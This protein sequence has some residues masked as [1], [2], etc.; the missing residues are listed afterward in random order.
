MKFL[1]SVN[2][3]IRQQLINTDDIRRLRKKAPCTRSEISMLKKQFW[4]DKIFSESI[5]TGE[6]VVVNFRMPS[7]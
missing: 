6:L 7:S 1:F 4:E 2:S 5:F 3:T